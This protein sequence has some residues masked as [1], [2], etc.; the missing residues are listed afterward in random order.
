MVKTLLPPSVELIDAVAEGMDDKVKNILESNSYNL[1]ALFDRCERYDDVK[2]IIHKPGLLHLAA[3]HGHADTVAALILAGADVNLQCK[4]SAP[5]GTTLYFHKTVLGCAILGSH[6]S[7]VKLLLEQENLDLCAL[8]YIIGWTECPP[9]FLVAFSSKL[10]LEDRKELFCLLV[11]AG[12][13]ISQQ[14]LLGSVLS[15]LCC[16]KDGALFC[17]LISSGK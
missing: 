6:M 13:D 9:L 17:L 10:T 16:N 14:S 5:Y 15:V 2:P 11:K 8:S 7:V 4:V 3:A 12:A 1:N